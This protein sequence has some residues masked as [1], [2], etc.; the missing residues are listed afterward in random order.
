MSGKPLKDQYKVRSA[1]KGNYF[2]I[3]PKQIEHYNLPCVIS[4]IL[5][6]SI[7]AKQFC[8]EKHYFKSQYFL[9]ELC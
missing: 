3:L 1:I 9:K 5:M 8:D 4:V 2:C 6:L 7:Y